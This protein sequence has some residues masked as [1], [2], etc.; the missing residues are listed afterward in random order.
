MD[1]FKK[2]VDDIHFPPPPIDRNPPPTMEKRI[3]NLLWKLN[4]GDKMIG[5]LGSIILLGVL[6]LFTWITKQGE[7]SKK[8]DSYINAKL[9]SKIKEITND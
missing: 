5:T 3:L 9:D 6:S 8:L 1:F 2:S 4:K 7:T